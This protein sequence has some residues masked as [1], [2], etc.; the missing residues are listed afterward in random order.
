MSPP[1]HT[2]VPH[3]SC[4]L[5]STSVLQSWFSQPLLTGMQLPSSRALVIGLA[6]FEAVLLSPSGLFQY[7]SH[8]TFHFS[9][10]HSQAWACTK[11]LCH[12]SHLPASN[13]WRWVCC[14]TGQAQG[15]YYSDPMASHPSTL[16]NLCVSLPNCK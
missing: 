13:G 3:S 10:L 8:V 6:Y 5:R 1:C 14:A 15:Y 2:R 7:R 4:S 11:Y 12:F 9:Y 16:S